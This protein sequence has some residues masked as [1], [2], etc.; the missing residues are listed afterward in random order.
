M[1]A[2][3]KSCDLSNTGIVMT[4]NDHCV[5]SFSVCVSI[6]VGSLNCFRICAAVSIFGMLIT[7]VLTTNSS[8]KLLV[9]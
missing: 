7:A 3:R 9:V 8:F 5:M 1:D 6:E 4:L 2:N